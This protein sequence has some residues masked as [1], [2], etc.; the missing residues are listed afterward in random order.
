MRETKRQILATL[1]ADDTDINLFKA[2]FKAKKLSYIPEIDLF[3]PPERRQNVDIK[4]L[5][6]FTFPYMSYSIEELTKFCQTIFTEG[7]YHEVLKVDKSYMANIAKAIAGEYNICAYHNFT[8]GFSALHVK[9]W[10][11]F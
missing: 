1:T 3:Q 7:N 6:D 8:H 9:V 2:K 10:E 4:E 11:L 5:R